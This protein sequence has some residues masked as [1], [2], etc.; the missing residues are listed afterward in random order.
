MRMKDRGPGYEIR[1]LPFSIERPDVGR[2]S[3]DC[4]WLRL[5]VFVGC[6]LQL[7]GE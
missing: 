6:T 4:L 3:L 1:E 2:G 5:M 7:P